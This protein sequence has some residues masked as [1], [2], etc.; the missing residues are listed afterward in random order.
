MSQPATWTVP[1]HVPEERVVDFDFMHP[2]GAESDVHAAWKT[3]HN[4]PDVVWSPYNGGHW[5]ATRAEDIETIQKDHSRFSHARVTVPRSDDVRLVPLELDPPEHTAYR[6]LITPPFLPQAIAS[7]ESDVRALTI[8]LIE[9]FKDKG[10]CEFVS[11]FAKMLPIV[12]FLR[13]VDLPQAD[14]LQLLEMAEL[15]V[16]GDL[17]ERQRSQGM[18][19]GYIGK[20]VQER[21]SNPGKD[22]IS[23]IVNAKIDGQPI[24]PERMFGMLVVVLFGGLDT[25][26]AMMSFICRFLAEHPAERRRLAESPELILTAVDELIR[27]HG[28]TNTARVVVEDMEFKGVQL[29]KGD[30]IQIPNALFGLDERR[31]GNPMEIDLER[32]PVLHA[33][34]G[35][36]PHRCPGSFLARTEIKVFLQEWLK[37]IPEF[38]I[39]A[40]EHP[41]CASGMVN[42][43]LYLPLQWKVA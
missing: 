28:V 21:T 42:G 17:E 6:T 26:A 19:M 2:P 32:K 41:R 9:G 35:N 30:Q 13:L 43:M 1:E 33:A 39:K 22:L 7:M 5:I 27:R 8:E 31:F 4:G 29:K 12:I 18:L 24:P 23:L 25:V 40:G 38:E 3:L 10:E 20:W 34:F 16:R 14:R 15:S 37:R 11:E 36:G